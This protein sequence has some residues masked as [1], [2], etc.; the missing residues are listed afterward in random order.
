MSN[1]KTTRFLVHRLDTLQTYFGERPI[2]KFQ[3]M[4]R[5]IGL[6]LKTLDK[7][8]MVIGCLKG[9]FRICRREATV[10]NAAKNYDV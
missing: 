4:S 1:V 5:V 8:N 2:F 6:I 10:I 7:L 9:F 3:G